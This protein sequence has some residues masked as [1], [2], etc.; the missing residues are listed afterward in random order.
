MLTRKQE[1][2][3]RI[4]VAKA[5]RFDLS[6]LA[7]SIP[8]SYGKEGGLLR[9][10]RNRI[11]LS[12]ELLEN[13]TYEDIKLVFT[14]GL[15]YV[16]LRHEIRRDV[17][18]LTSHEKYVWAIASEVC[19]GDFI[20]VAVPKL[21]GKGQIPF[22]KR[23]MINDAFQCLC[24]NWSPIRYGEAVEGI[25]RR[26]MDGIAELSQKGESEVELHPVLGPSNGEEEPAENGTTTEEATEDDAS[27][28][29]ET[30]S[31]AEEAMRNA[32][33]DAT[34]IF[35]S[36][37]ARGINSIPG[38]LQYFYGKLYPNYADVGRLRRLLHSLMFGGHGKPTTTNRRRRR[39]PY[40]DIILFQYGRK[41]F[42][43]IAVLAD[44]SASTSG[45]RDR[46]FE[47][48]L[49]SLKTCDRIDLFVGDTAVLEKRL[50]VCQSSQLQGIPDG[51]G[52]DMGAIISQIDERGYRY[53]VV[54]S[55]GMTPW[56]SVETAATTL[57]FPYG[58]FTLEGVPEWIKIV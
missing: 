14:H 32:V 4:E 57:Y 3:L 40:K 43:R 44:V 45:S 55:D 39:N 19:R 2:Q 37:Y 20:E 53:I 42:G 35:L 8:I 30:D 18:A 1:F 52:T 15:C 9:V 6:R 22:I 5:S 54:I 49:A 29:A 17:V 12:E 48:L 56:P 21:Q 11:I 10:V 26:I 34:K 7:V 28:M 24:T 25:Y 23:E 38:E 41:G 50:R 27:S 16:L 47:I 36:A 51:G 33:R 58:D 31:A 13:Y 46:L